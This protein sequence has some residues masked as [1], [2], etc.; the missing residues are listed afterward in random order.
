MENLLSDKIKIDDL[1]FE[2]GIKLLENVVSSVES[3]NA[4][5]EKVVLAYESGMKILEMLRSRIS[6]AEEKLRVIKNSQ[7]Q[8]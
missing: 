2:E 3:G 1:T 6:G 4:P 8:N 7:G 5:L